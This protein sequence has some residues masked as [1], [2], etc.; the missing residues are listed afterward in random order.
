VYNMHICT[1]AEPDT[2]SWQAALQTTIIIWC[3]DTAQYGCTMQ[4]ACKDGP[5]LLQQGI[6]QHSATN[7]VQPTQGQK[8]DHWKNLPIIRPRLAI[9]SHHV[10]RLIGL[11]ADAVHSHDTCGWPQQLHALDKRSKFLDT[12]QSTSLLATQHITSCHGTNIY[13]KVHI[14]WN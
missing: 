3:M 6:H 9:V 12:Q 11:H 5:T 10:A 1:P 8:P 13:P 14:C 4:A 2:G 7:T